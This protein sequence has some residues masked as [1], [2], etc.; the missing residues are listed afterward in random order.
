[1]RKRTAMGRG[2]IYDIAAFVSL[3]AGVREVEQQTA[4]ATQS[5]IPFSILIIY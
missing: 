4:Q 2:M 1:V 5:F 3:Q